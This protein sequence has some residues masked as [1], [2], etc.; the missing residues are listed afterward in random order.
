MQRLS[1]SYCCKSL[2]QLDPKKMLQE[3]ND[4]LLTVMM[5]SITKTSNAVLDYIEKCNVAY[6]RL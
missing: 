3:F 1:D 6:N 5:S 2:L 4:A